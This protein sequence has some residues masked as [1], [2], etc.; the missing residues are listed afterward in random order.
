MHRS[1]TRELTWCADCGSELDPGRDRAYGFG[2]EAFLCYACAER[3]GGIY[4]EA[5]DRWLRDPD[6]G[7]LDVGEG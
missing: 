4:D 5:H 1:E 6:T 3:R 2:P 7:G